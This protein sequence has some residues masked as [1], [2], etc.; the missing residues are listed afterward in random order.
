MK[1]KVFFSLSSG[2][3]FSLVHSP[4]DMPME[5]RVVDHSTIRLS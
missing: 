4:K 1:S 2:F 3:N 5:N